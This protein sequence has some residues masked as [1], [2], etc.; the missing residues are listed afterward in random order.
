M[1]DDQDGCEWV[2]VPKIGGPC[3][4]PRH[5]TATGCKGCR[6]ARARIGLD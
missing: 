4:T 6:Q 5:G 2:S 3:P 1:S